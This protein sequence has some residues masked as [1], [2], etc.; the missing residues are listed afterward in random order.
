[1][2]FLQKLENARKK[3]N[4]L[5]CVGLDTDL[6][7]VPDNIKK[8]AESLFEF[9]KAIIDATKDLVCCYKPNIAFYEAEGIPGLQALEKTIDYIPKDIPIILDAKRGDIGNT[10]D[11]YAAAC[12][13][14]MKVDAVTLSPYMGYDSISP[15]AKY[16]GKA[17]FIL[18]KTSNNSA[19]DFQ[20]V[21]NAAGEPLY[22]TVARKIMAWQK[23]SAATLGAVAG[24]TYP[25]DLKAI[26]EVL[27]ELPILIP[28]LGSQGGEGQKTV[29]FGAGVSGKSPIMI[30]S[31]RAIIHASSNRDFAEVARNV[32][33][34]TKEQLNS[35][36][37]S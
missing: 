20:D 35:Y 33:I 29:K 2:N 23:E 1:M 18:V 27:G 24:A 37:I 28:G 26:R 31:S 17:I 34:K 36:L 21:K 4:S 11:K 22:I 14:Q 25:E 30:N 3:N 19:I 5:L 12:F 6:S 16:S 7:K 15:F 13:D 32:A 9:N 10:C 8:S